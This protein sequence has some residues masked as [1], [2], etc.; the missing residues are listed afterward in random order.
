MIINICGVLLNSVTVIIPVEVI[1]PK[2]GFYKDSVS[3]S[4]IKV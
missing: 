2:S 4:M 1:K 3:F